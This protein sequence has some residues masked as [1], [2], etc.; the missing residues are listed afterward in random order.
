MT[1]RQFGYLAGFLFAW[2]GWVA[3]FWVA[4]GAVVIGL[5]GYGA[6]RVLEGDLDLAG[7]SERFGPTS[8]R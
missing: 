5:I 4:L 1:R 6:A 8:R 3:S 2:L 7:L